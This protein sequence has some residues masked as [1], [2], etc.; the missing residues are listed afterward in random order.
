MTWEDKSARDHR[1]PITRERYF[2]AR[3]HL[4]QSRATLP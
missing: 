3:E 1:T 4:I 2:A